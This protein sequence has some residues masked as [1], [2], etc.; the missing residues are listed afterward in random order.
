MKDNLFSVPPCL[1]ENLFNS[2]YKILLA[3][4][5]SLPKTSLIA[6]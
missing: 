6:T 2:S 5:R 4:N 3:H 1:C